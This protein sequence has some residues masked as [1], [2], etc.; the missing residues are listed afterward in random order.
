MSDTPA[1]RMFAS[2]YYDLGSALVGAG[3]GEKSN[4]DDALK[5]LEKSASLGFVPAQF[6]LGL[7]YFHGEA[8]FKDYAQAF[9][10][11]QKAAS[12]GHIE[13][14]YYLGLSY[15]RGLGVEPSYPRGI[16]WLQQAA[17]QGHA[18]AMYM[19]GHIYHLGKGVIRSYLKAAY[20]YGKAADKGHALAHKELTKTIS[21]NDLRMAQPLLAEG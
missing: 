20:W 2:K 6:K 12:S 18:D 16:Y 17:H 4:L 8:G 9:S 10:W 21:L 1:N 5:W 15:A 19:L 13:A 11:W 7:T 3:H 14:Q